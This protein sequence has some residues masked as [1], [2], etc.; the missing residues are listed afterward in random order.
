MATNTT[1]N[2]RIVDSIPYDMESEQAE[3]GAVLIDSRR[4]VD[5]L[6]I[7]S[8]DDL[9]ILRNRYVLE[10]MIALQERQEPIDL[11]T[12]SKELESRNQLGDVGGDMYLATL[13]GACPDVNS[14]EYYAG[15]VASKAYDRR[16]LGAS[17]Q[18][19]TLALDGRIKLVDKQAQVDAVIQ[20]ADHAKG[21]EVTTMYAAMD[22]YMEY[23]AS[24]AHMGEG[25]SGLATGFNEWDNLLDGLQEGSLN[26]VA[27]RPGMGKTSLLH[28]VALYVA[29]HGG[30]VYLWSG[31]MPV[32]QVRERMMS[33]KTEMQGKLLRR[34][35]RPG[36]MT[37]KQWEAFGHSA[38]ELGQLPIH[39]DDER[40]ITPNILE[41]RA[42]RI[43]RR[44]PLALIVVDYIGLIRPG[45][46]KENRDKELGYISQR[47]KE[48]AAIAP[49]LCAAQLSRAVEKRQD[50][51]PVM[52]DLRDSGNLE[53]DSDTVTFV[54]R[55]EV[56]NEATESPNS[57]ELIMDKNRHGATGT[58]YLY[59]DK[60]ITKF[61]NAV[62]RSVNLEAFNNGQ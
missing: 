42:R 3:L 51:R 25:I 52:S 6:A 13:I 33:I 40:G 29:E 48:I 47:L 7:H 17:D 50:K 34:G 12:V 37:Q 54:Y 18:I 8:A 57:A 45:V 39:I 55:D 9:F 46:K 23:M 43:A 27:A 21:N 16:L 44:K 41:A 30:S 62:T 26:L 31:E 28:A 15:R 4:L 24:T 32:K 59:F 53:Q 56:Y 60:T 11:L 14:V 19:R 36:G 5:V 10:S 61:M 2:I 35:L 1:N 38:Y 20:D 58:S 49:V 22:E